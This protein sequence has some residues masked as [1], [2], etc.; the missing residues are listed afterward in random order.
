MT[1]H[2]NN[3][4]QTIKTMLHYSISALSIAHLRDAK[5]LFKYL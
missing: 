3:L 4:L 1:Y 2:D 5:I